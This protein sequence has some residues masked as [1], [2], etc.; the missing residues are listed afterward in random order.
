MFVDEVKL[1][2]ISGKGGNGAA[3]FRREKYVPFGGPS[4]GDGGRGGSI[5]F[6]AD[7]NLSTLLDFKYLKKITAKNGENGRT[8]NQYGACAEDTYV[9]V[10]VG[11]TVYDNDT[12]LVIVDLTVH[13]QEFVLCKG[14]RGG[15][16][17]IHFATSRN[18]APEFSENGEPG[19]TKNIRIELKVLADVGLVGFPSVGKSTLI[20]RV[21][22]ATPRIASYHFTTLNPHLGLVRSKDG[23]SFVMADLPGLIEGASQGLGLGIRFLKHIE[24]CR[25]I[26][27]VIDMAKTDGRDPYTDYVTIRNELK[28]YKMRLLDRPEIIVANKMDNE[29]AKANLEEF[30][31]HFDNDVQ[32][33]E[34]SALTNQ[35][36]DKLVY[37][38][39]DTLEVTNF[40]DIYE[41]DEIDDVV[42]YT[43]NPIDPGFKV[44]KSPDGIFDVTG[45]KIDKI[46]SM[47]NFM[48]EQSI[49]RFARKLRSIGVD[50]ALREAGVKNGDTVRVNDYEFEFVD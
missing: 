23:R 47:T 17:N 34:I 43:F 45:D 50:Q 48:Q 32:V 41:E 16:G 3:T 46:M 2:C 49:S 21:S 25:V 13:G 9:K 29:D 4:G 38:I 10:P 44:T 37:K 7:E 36:L 15:R 18:K 8:K 24:R 40:F 31:S 19:E 30:K 39:C 33:I 20:S 22:N 42:T 14:G 35:G 6:V 5:I 27:H 11:S 28:A 1:T 12:G 26:V